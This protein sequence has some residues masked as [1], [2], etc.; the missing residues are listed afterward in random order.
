VQV[1]A[2]DLQAVEEQAG[3]ARVEGVGGDAAQ[4]FA[5][6]VLDGGAVFGVGELEGGVAGLVAGEARG[7][8]GGF[9][10]RFGTAGGV[11]VVAEILVAQ[12]AG[13]AAEASGLDVAALEARG[14]GDGRVGA[15]GL[16]FG[17]HVWG[18]HPG[19]SV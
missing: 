12:A 17:R 14:V 1:H 2:G 19:K 3:A 18:T 16:E 5:D 15:A 8:R 10:Y 6:R 11:V 7:L 4:D 13:A 9:E